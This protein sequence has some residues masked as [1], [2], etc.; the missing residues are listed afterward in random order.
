MNKKYAIFDMDGTLIDSMTYWKNLGREYLSMQ[1]VPENLDAVMEEI[2]PLT[3]TESAELFRTRFSLSGT[4]ESIAASMNWMIEEHYRKDIPLKNGVKDYL[5]K[6]HASGVKMCVASAT[7]KA[8]M[9]TCLERLGIKGYFEFILSCEEVGAG[10]RKPDVYFEAVRRMENQEKISPES[11]AVFEDADYAIHTALEAGF[12]TIA[13]YDDSNKDKWEKLKMQ[14]REFIEDW[15]SQSQTMLKK[16]TALTIAGS[17]CSGG[18]GIQA[19]LKTM[20]MN[21]VYAM[22]VITALTAQNTTGVRSI[23]EVT[24]TFLREQM[25]AIFEDIRPDAVKIGMVSSSH[26]I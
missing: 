17:D 22:S 15:E 18:A 19:D 13:V 7:D 11:V 2:K 3:M 4:K 24:P 10:K 8:L 23:M 1:G 6:L 14:T 9:E 25:D 21:G 5:A 26:L 16:K 12:Y 20:T